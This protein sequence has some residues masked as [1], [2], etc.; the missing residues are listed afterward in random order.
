MLLLIDFIKDFVMLG[1]K[2]QDITALS[3]DYV[4]KI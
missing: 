3:I 2:L 1:T 4:I